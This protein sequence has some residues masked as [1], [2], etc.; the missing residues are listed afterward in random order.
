MAM[1]V[2]G[3]L[4]KSMQLLENVIICHYIKLSSFLKAV[5]LFISENMLLGR[6]K[7]VN[8]SRSLQNN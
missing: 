1:Q 2:P 6:T 7:K 8:N 3:I 5:H 4:P